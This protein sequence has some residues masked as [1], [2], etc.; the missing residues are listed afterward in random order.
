MAETVAVVRKSIDQRLADVLEYRE[1]ARHVTVE[2]GVTDR[3]L[4]FISGGEHN[5]SVLVGKRHQQRTANARLNILF[6]G[7]FGPATKLLRERVLETGHDGIDRNLVVTHAKHGRHGARIFEA[8]RCV[9]H[10]WQ[11]QGTDPACAQRIDRY[12]QRQRRIDAS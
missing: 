8:D 1:T 5:R 10:R 12:R 9:V 3:H 6:G 11:H 7:V 4:R 2:C